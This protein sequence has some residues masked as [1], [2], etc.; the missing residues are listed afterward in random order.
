MLKP[1]DQMST[2][3]IQSGQDKSARTM[4]RCLIVIE[5]D[6]Q[7]LEAHYHNERWR[8]GFTD[9]QRAFSRHGFQKIQG[10]AYLS[11]HG[12][13]QAHGAITI[14]L[15]DVAIRHAWFG[16]CVSNVQ[17]YDLVDHFN[18]QFTIDCAA[19]ARQAF[20]HQI[21]VLCGQL[22]DVGLHVDKVA[23]IIGQ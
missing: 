20:E 1:E 6:T 9:I 4:N 7:L 23:E 2:G 21:G 11:D 19:Q 15:Q 8:D 13:H 10:T 16:Q 14:A 5:L 22:I 12:V 18:A 3:S 17:F